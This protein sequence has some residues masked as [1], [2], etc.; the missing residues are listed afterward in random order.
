MFGK[1]I[2][3]SIHN[4]VMDRHFLEGITVFCDALGKENYYS[5]RV[6]LIDPYTVC[7]GHLC[8]VKGSTDLG[9]THPTVKIAVK[10]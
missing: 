1:K 3:P 6:T 9:T 5:Y 8:K 10:S 7:F 2:P 4:V